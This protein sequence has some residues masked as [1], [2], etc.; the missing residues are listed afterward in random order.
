MI[1]WLLV[2]PDNTLLPGIDRGLGSVCKVELA[3]DVTD[4][5]FYGVLT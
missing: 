2:P 3:E 1:D 5:P 4:V